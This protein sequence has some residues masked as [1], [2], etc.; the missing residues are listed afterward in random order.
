MAKE[1]IKTLI[2]NRP[3]YQKALVQVNQTMLTTKVKISE[4]V[5]ITKICYHKAIVVL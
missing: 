5:K 4:V 1:L 3:N 2:N